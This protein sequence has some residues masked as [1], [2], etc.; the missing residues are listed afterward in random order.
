[1]KTTLFINFL[2]DYQ[3]A[4]SDPSFSL[5]ILLE[6]F[7]RLLNMFLKFLIPHIIPIKSQLDNYEDRTAREVVFPV[8]LAAKLTRSF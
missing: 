8:D 7:F 3:I 1:M 2:V 6:K 5:S 4:N